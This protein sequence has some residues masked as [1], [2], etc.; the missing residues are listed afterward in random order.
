MA[1]SAAALAIR[2][3]SG[4]AAIPG[5]YPGDESMKSIKSLD[6]PGNWPSP[7]RSV[8]YARDAIAGR[9]QETRARDPTLS[10][11]LVALLIV[12]ELGFSLTQLFWAFTYPCFQTNSDFWERH[13]SGTSTYADWL[14]GLAAFIGAVGI[15]GAFSIVFAGVQQAILY[16]TSW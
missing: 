13:R 15:V 10:G 1:S 2:K 12:S 6:V 4:E 3:P 5:T 16:V 7:A 11:A 9:L 8:H 14:R